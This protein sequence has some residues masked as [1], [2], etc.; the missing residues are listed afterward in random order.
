MIKIFTLVLLIINLIDAYTPTTPFNNWHCIDFVKNIDKTKPYAYNIGELPLV[1][2]FNKKEIPYTS[3]N[4]C[5]HMGSKLDE[6]IVEKECLKCPY[7]GLKYDSEKMFGET[8]IFQNKLWWSYEPVKKNPPLVPSYNDKRF[9][10]SFIKID[11]EASVNDCVLNAMD[12]NHPEFIHN[13]IFG[14]GSSIPP[15]NVQTI[16]YH[17]DDMKV[18]LSFNYKKGMKE[19]RNVH[20]YEFPYSSWSHVFLPNKKQLVVNIDMLPL[21]KDKTRWCVTLKHNY[22]KSNIEKI[23]MKFI[24]K[25]ILY[26]D[27]QQMKRQANES[28]LKSLIM[29]KTQL[30]NEE[31]FDEIKKILNNYKYPSS[32]KVVLLY[33]YHMTKK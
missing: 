18:G 32:D 15:T 14:F 10:T 28:I 22:F 26:Q 7:H 21:S 25:C 24:T 20:V 16:S 9:E 2:W 11:V 13:T 19:S 12:M 31:H 6:G 5:E 1:T 8:M 29:N 27:Q 33:N 17:K 4:I 23:L 30:K 3:I